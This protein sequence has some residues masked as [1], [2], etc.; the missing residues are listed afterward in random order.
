MIW[1]DGSGLRG[2]TK[3]VWDSIHVVG[4]KVLDNNRAQYQLTTT[5]IL[6]LATSQNSLD[7]SGY[8]Q[9]QV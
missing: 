9:R 7:L 4:V 3:G 6:S 5:I 1:V 2:V 8:I